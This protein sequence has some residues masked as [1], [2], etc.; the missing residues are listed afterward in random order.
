[1]TDASSPDWA[2]GLDVKFL[3]SIAQLFRSYKPYAMGRFSI[4]NEAEIARA[5]SSNSGYVVAVGDKPL[6]FMI[7]SI[8]Q[9]DSVRRDFAGRAL[10]VKQGDFSI[11]HLAF[12]DELPAH[13]LQDHLL[14]YA[15]NRSVWALIHAENRAK[16]RMM[17]SLG[18]QVIGTK[19]GA[20]S[21]MHSILLRSNRPAIRLPEP[22]DAAHRPSLAM[23]SERFIT[24][25]ELSDIRAEIARGVEW[26]DHYSSYNLRHS[27][28]AISLRGYSDDPSFIIKPAEMSKKWR[29]AHWAMLSAPVRD[30][31]LMA[32]FPTVAAV[33][34]RLGTDLQRVRF[35]RVRAEDGGLSRHA[36]I[37]DREAGPMPGQIAR[38]HIPINS[39]PVCRFQAWNL[40]GEKLQ[41]HLPERSLWYLDTRKPH[42]V[43]N[44]GADHDRIHLVIDAVSTEALCRWIAASQEEPAA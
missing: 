10:Y 11:Q 28:S 24:E 30:T 27:W 15:G 39:E 32:R 33:C 43:S 44:A 22:L 18:F 12:A 29:E 8:A 1:M 9:R 17:E 13:I 16:I 41:A 31:P 37:T 21:E 42:A 34:S 2:H 23:L 38:L 7:A 20:S 5:I 14:Q 19:I 3:K 6:G 25:Q 26:A 40:A 36:D 4:P 35:M